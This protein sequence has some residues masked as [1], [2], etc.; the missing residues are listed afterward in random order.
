MEKKLQKPY[1]T[2]STFINAR[3]LASSLSNLLENLAEGI[4]KTKRKYGHDNKK[5]RN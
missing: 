2:K 4:H 5:I 3:F 1:P